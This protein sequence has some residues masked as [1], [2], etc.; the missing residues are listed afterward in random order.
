[1]SKHNADLPSKGRL[2]KRIVYI[3]VILVCVALLLLYQHEQQAYKE[4]DPA[5][6]VL[7]LPDKT[8]IQDPKVTV[9]LDAAA[10]QGLLLKPM[11]D[12]E[13]MNS[14]F[15][16]SQVSGVILPDQV[17]KV[18]SD[19]LIDTLNQYVTHGGHLMLVYDAGTWTLK[20]KYTQHASR[21]SGLAGISYANYHQLRAKVSTWSPIVASRATFEALQ[22]PPGKYAPYDIMRKDA[23]TPAIDHK[24][25]DAP[26]YSLS[27]YDHPVLSYDSFTTSGTYQG[28]VLMQTVA[29]SVAAGIHRQGKGKVLFVN[30]PLAYLKSRTDGMLMHAFVHYFAVH[31]NNLPYLASTPDARGGLVMNLHLGSNVA[32]PVLEKIRA[33]GIFKQGPFSIHITAGPDAHRKG[34]GLGI[35]VPHN[36]KT[37]EW[38]KFF[39]SRGDAIGSHGGWVHDYWGEFVP[40]KPTPE[41]ENLLK[42]NK[43][44][45]EKVTGQP[46]IEYSAPQGS[47][48]AWVT[49]WLSKHGFIA[50]YFTG[51][52]GMAPTRS[53]LNN[54]IVSPTLW[55]YPILTYQDM[56]GFE[57]LHADDVSTQ[58]VT[59]W[60]HAI[61]RFCADNRTV[62]LIYFHPRGGLLY[63]KAI[64]SWLAQSAKLKQS[65][66]FRWYTM[67]GLSKF[68]NRR[69]QTQW[70]ITRAGAKEVFAA[71]NPQSLAN[72]VWVLSKRLYTKPV[73]LAGK[74]I[75]KTDPAHW[76]IHAGY[77]KALQFTTE[78]IVSP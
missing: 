58:Q 21:L 59:D 36:K 69:L 49:D 51:D 19:V 70:H 38:I 9:W 50:Y 57:E 77:G 53:Y 1:M 63:P 16:R 42:L 34:D 72:H 32:L 75:I 30:L 46:V 65:G 48:P 67:S 61:D 73:I 71:E 11:T 28:T 6:L 52:S 35:D 27:G 10:E 23:K 22:V 60:L 74:A 29:G 14:W 44:A 3:G 40:D 66:K 43:E 17:H 76:L 15:D 18:A 4:A 47:H 56:A 33:L 26:L 24:L 54:K 2:Y 45:L 41:F 5:T 64:R 12:S 55:S 37:Q 13:F 7:L 68:L 25:V 31:M 62:R 78:R 39:Q 20:Q 8:N